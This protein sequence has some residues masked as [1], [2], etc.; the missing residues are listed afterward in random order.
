MACTRQ[1]ACKST[2]GKAPQKQLATKATRKSALAAG[3]VKKPHRYRP[4]IV[5]L[6]EI[7]TGLAASQEASEAY[8]I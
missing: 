6:C 5:A 2:G 7:S 1:T 4:G 8:L 3:D